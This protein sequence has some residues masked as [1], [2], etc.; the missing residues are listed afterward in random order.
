MKP[1]VAPARRCARAIWAAGV[2]AGLLALPPA[3]ADAVTPLPQRLA[4]TGLHLPGNPGHLQPGVRSFTPQYPLWSDGARKRR[5]IRLPPGGTVDATK[6]D[7]WDFPPGTRLWKEFSLGA[8]VE[9]RFIERLADGSW[10]YTTYAWN[11]EGSEALLVPERGATVA[12]ASAPGGRYRLPA[13]ADCRACHEGGASPVLGFSALQLSDDRDPEAPHAE[14]RSPQDLGLNDLVAQGLLRGLPQALRDTPPRIAAPTPRA[15]AA[16][17]YLHA[18]CGH[19]HNADGPLASLEMVLAQPAM[20][21]PYD[22]NRTLATLAGTRATPDNPQASPLLRRLRA[23]NPNTRMPPLGVQLPDAGA[24]VTL[25]AWIGHDF[26]ATA[27][28]TTPLRKD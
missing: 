24:L 1:P 17:G 20:G 28:A 21:Q 4:D 26:P 9:T 6:P 15:R 23:A 2:A 19:C 22:R 10:R 16:L 14:A 3:Q 25:E 18:N 12:M 11:A 27:P 13:Q 7:A 5:W 8:R